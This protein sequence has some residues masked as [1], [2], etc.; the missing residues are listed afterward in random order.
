MEGREQALVQAYAVFLPAEQSADPDG[1][2]I[3]DHGAGSSVHHSGR[4]G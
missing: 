1:A 2:D 3:S 4:A